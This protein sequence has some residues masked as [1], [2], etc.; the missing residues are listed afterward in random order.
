MPAGVPW[1]TYTKFTMA[2]LF[3]MF[4]GSQCVHQVYRPL[5]DLPD[6]IKAER[7]QKKCAQ[8][9]KDIRTSDNL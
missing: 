4:L 3:S 8:E 9:E 1:T 6:L 2:A 5:D 7:K